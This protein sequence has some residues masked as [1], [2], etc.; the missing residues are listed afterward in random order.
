MRARRA[1]TGGA[2]TWRTGRSHARSAY[3]DDDKVY[4][5]CNDVACSAYISLYAGLYPGSVDAQPTSRRTEFPPCVAQRT[6]TPQHISRDMLILYPNLPTP[7][8]FIPCRTAAWCVVPASR[9]PAAS[10]ATQARPALPAAASATDARALALPPPS[11][12]PRI[13]VALLLCNGLMFEPQCLTHYIQVI[14]P[15]SFAWSNTS[16]SFSISLYHIFSI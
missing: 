4:A 9:P 14:I 6:S 7:H 8:Q 15:K 12:P 10:S 5:R 1:R 11:F 3:T 2:K 13:H 16:F